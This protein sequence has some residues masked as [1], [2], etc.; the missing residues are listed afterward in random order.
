MRISPQLLLPMRWIF[1]ATMLEIPPDIVARMIAEGGGGRSGGDRTFRSRRQA[2]PDFRGAMPA[3]PVGASAPAVPSTLARRFDLGVFMQSEPNG[4]DNDDMMVSLFES[5][6]PLIV[7]PYI[8]KDG[9]KL[10]HAVLLTAAGRRCASTTGCRY[11]QGDI[12]DLLIVLNEKT[13]TSRTRFTAPKWRSIS[14]ATTS[15]FRSKVPAADIDVTNA[16]L[17]YV[18]DVSER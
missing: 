3:W 2:R 18:A 10:D 17:S 9:L 13:D 7:V 1:R 15:R 16:I 5:G 8:Q 14:P 6:R 12:I 4:V 11:Y